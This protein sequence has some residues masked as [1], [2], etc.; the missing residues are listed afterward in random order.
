MLTTRANTRRVSE[1]RLLQLFST[2]DPQ[3][4]QTLLAFAEFLADRDQGRPP[5]PSPVLEPAT[6]PRPDK[7]S[8]MGAIKRLARTYY[9]LERKEMLNE[10]SMLMGQ[11]VLHGRSAESVIDDLERLF[12]EQYARYLAA[13]SQ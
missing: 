12:A 7:E 8:I 4:R 1:R 13:H 10:T 2:L 5:E 9:M 6:V 11:H 3:D